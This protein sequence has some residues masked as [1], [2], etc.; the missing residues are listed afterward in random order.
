M[1]IGHDGLSIGY[2]HAT[3]FPGA[4]AREMFV[5]SQNDSRFHVLTPKIAEPFREAVDHFGSDMIATGPAV[6]RH[7]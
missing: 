5:V 4:V 3:R 7:S 1:L 2:L 6:E